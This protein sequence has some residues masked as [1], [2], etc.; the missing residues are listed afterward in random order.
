[1][2]DW[3]KKVEFM[4]HILS[5][6]GIELSKMKVDAILNARQPES[7]SE[8][9]S[10]LGLVNFSG[11]FIPNLAT[12]S[13]PLRKLTRKKEKFHWGPD[14]ENAFNK[15]EN[16]LAKVC[17]LG[18]CDIRS[19]TQVIA[20]ASP[21]GLGAVL[22]QKQ[23]NEY[24]IICYAS[25]SLTD[26]E[27]RYSQTEKEALALVWACERFQMYVQGTGYDLVTDNRPLQ[28]IFSKRSKPCACVERMV[29]RLQSFRY[30][31]K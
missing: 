3:S 8:V 12:L 23:G 1:M 31:V 18:Y 4:G 7:E 20:D 16:E 13:E 22:A 17:T 30:T 28:F 24:R 10:F 19:K 14:Q 15:L 5:E 2:S 29:L 11:R 26:V 27:K 9:R 6:Q 21:V 25:R